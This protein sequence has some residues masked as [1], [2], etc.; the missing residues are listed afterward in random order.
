[1]SPNLTTKSQ[2]A[3]SSAVQMATA[4]GN[5]Q[6]EPLWDVDFRA[7]PVGEQLFASGDRNADLAV[8]LDYEG[9][10]PELVDDPLDAIRRC[11]PG[12]VE[13][14]ANYTAFRDLLGALKQAGFMPIRSAAGGTQ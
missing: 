5:P 11:Q 4:A 10:A 2:E 3:L 6:V 1:M 14:L 9:L 12:E 8:R 13:L 7:L